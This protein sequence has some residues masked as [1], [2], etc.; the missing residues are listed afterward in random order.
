ML[1]MFLAGGRQ[2]LPPAR[3]INNKNASPLGLQVADR[4]STDV[5]PSLEKVPPNVAPNLCAER[6]TRARE[7]PC[8]AASWTYT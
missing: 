3:V 6:K 2:S 8:C 4:L 7:H 1:M 5:V